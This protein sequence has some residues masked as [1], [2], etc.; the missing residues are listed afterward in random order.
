VSGRIGSHTHPPPHSHHTHATPNPAGASHTCHTPARTTITRMPPVLHEHHTHA[1]PV[2][3][4]HHTR[5]TPNPTRASHACHTP[6][7]TAITR[8]P[9]PV[10]LGHHTHATPHPARASNMPPVLHGHHTRATTHPARASAGRRLG[11]NRVH[12]SAAE[13]CTEWH[14]IKEKMSDRTSVIVR[15][16]LY[17]QSRPIIG[18]LPDAI[19]VLRHLS[20]HTSAA[21]RCTR[22]L[23]NLRPTDASCRSI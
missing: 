22:L 12:R 7:R 21:L 15:G 13:V 19:I 4:G 14:A 6:S 1:T 2:L 9:H 5:A 23:P 11:R 3:L 20:V 8:M 10:L 18:V 17:Q 16:E